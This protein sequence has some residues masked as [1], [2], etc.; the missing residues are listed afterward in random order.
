[1]KTSKKL[2][3]ALLAVFFILACSA[4]P[5]GA[6][7]REFVIDS[8]TVSRTG[9]CEVIGHY[10]GVELDTQ[11]SCVVAKDAL[12]DGNAVVEENFNTDYVAWLGQEGTGNN[13]T[14]LFQFSVPESFS[15]TKLIV[16][17]TSSYGD[18]A[19][20]NIDIPAL[21]PGIE[22]VEDNSV[23]YGRDAFYVPGVF[24][25]PDNIADSIVYGG[26]N[27]YF[28]I[29]GLW[30]DLMDEK[31]ADNSFLVKENATPEKIIVGLKPRYYYSMTNKIEFKYCLK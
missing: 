12:F 1:M 14:F 15:E 16:R 3:A 5:V 9:Y 6:D 17:L 2:F 18:I 11:M 21:P 23:I 4:I 25:T 26:N 7:S 28:K 13:G 22:V 27:I 30:Y 24:Y 10:E 29:G 8:A 19:V 20:T 31:A